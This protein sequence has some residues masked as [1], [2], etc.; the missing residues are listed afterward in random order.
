LANVLF[1]H[2]AQHTGRSPFVGPGISENPEVR[3]LIEG[4]EGGY[5]YPP[6][7]GSDGTLYLKAR[8]NGEEGVYAFYPNGTQK[9]YYPSELIYT[10]H[11][12]I[13]NDDSI[14]FSVQLDRYKTVALVMLNSDGTLKW[15]KSPVNIDLVGYPVSKGGIIYFLANTYN[16]P[17]KLI[18]LN[19]TSG[20]F[21]WTY[22]IEENLLWETPAVGPDGTIYFGHK[23]TL[24]ALNPDGTEKWK[25]KFEP[26]CQYFNC[27]PEV[28][29]PSVS[30]NG[31][32]YVIVRREK[33]F[34]SLRDE[35]TTPCF[36][37]IDPETGQDINWQDKCSKFF[38][39][40]PATISSQNNI[41]LVGGY[42]P[43]GAWITFIYGFNRQGDTLEN[44][45]GLRIGYLGHP[46]ALTITDNQ[47]IIYGLFGNTLKA[48]DLSGQEIWSV[49]LQGGR[50]GSVVL[51]N[52]QTLYVGGADK[53]YAI[54][55]DIISQDW[56][57]NR[58]F[59]YNLDN[60]YLT[61]EGT[62]HLQGTATL[63]DN[64]TLSL[65]NFIS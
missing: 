18:A 1:Q 32:I 59:Q 38:G 51:G 30:D 49:P 5:F 8:I 64:G 13:I 9:W 3:V 53:L 21:L 46:G 57:F 62:G 44:W 47:N 2:D 31:T 4:K 35:G 28:Q 34:R 19:S 39:S 48:I 25:R 27:Q 58:D 15:K 42:A 33:D 20:D 23:D 54:G 10:G 26:D 41:F 61:I 29:T 37:S 16:G 17:G 55:P 63:Y 24:Y 11:L 22:E 56:S 52:N 7:I 14:F 36:H 6:L 45:N 40:G 12:I 43:M 50:V 60:N 65:W